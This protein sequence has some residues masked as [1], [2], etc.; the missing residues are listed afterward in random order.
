MSYFH[1]SRII[2]AALSCL[3]ITCGCGQKVRDSVK[4][5]DTTAIENPAPYAQI[6]ML[7][8]ADYTAGQAP[9][10]SLRR[11]IKIQSAITERLA[12][13]GYYVPVE[14]DVVQYMIDLG[15]IQLIESPAIQSHRSRTTLFRE[16]GT[17]WS[18]AMKEQ[19]N[20]V[21][22]ENE[23]VNVAE[24][25]LKMNHIGLNKGIVKQIGKY[26]GADFV[27][28]G[29]IVEYEMR[30]GRILN[31]LQQGILPFFFDWTSATIFGVA[32]SDQYDLWQDL[33]LG[34]AM[35]AGLGSMANTPFNSPTSSTEVVGSH[36]RFAH[37]VTTTSGGYEHSTA[38]NAGFWGA[39]GMAAAYLAAKG[40]HVP[41]AVVQ[42][43]LALQDAKT[44][45]VVWAN[46]VE[47][48]VE[49]IT[50]WADPSNRTQI[51]RAVEE[52]AKALAGDLTRVLAMCQQCSQQVQ[53]A[54]AECQE[55]AIPGQGL[56]EEPL[57][58]EPPDTLGDTMVINKTLE[59]SG[60]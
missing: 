50:M 29:R 41:R 44:G 30:E 2:F 6:V 15:V 53:T 40:G 59:T 26:F 56:Q 5:V 12:S 14:E 57:I 42:I 22:L 25:K 17:G 16:L 33:A 45:K 28:R 31:P 8:F 13:A 46:R 23:L 10:D 9:D 54:S 51:D 32:E 34:G 52:A 37:T 20:N 7:P 4:P 48:Q 60:S 1:W 49:P 58:V 35:G 39:A 38:Y 18:D 47:K 3:V 19:I 27:L 24:E 36:P 11:Q 21:M 43:S 55:T